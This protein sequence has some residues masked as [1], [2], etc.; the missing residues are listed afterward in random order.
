MKPNKRTTAICPLCGQIYIDHPA[1]SRADN[2]T[3]ICPDCGTREA[4]Q[5]LGIDAT[6]QDKIIESI[7]RCK[8]NLD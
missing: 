6:E 8:A 4:L 2:E 3:L 5:G 1:I 7:H